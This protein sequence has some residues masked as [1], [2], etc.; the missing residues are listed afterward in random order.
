MVRA[1]P[2]PILLLILSERYPARERLIPSGLKRF[3][4]VWNCSDLMTAR[5][6]YLKWSLW[7]GVLAISAG[8][9][10]LEAALD[11]FLWHL[12]YGGSAGVVVGAGFALSRTH[13]PCH[14]SLW[15]LIGYAYMIVPDLLWALPLIWGGDVYSHQPWMDIFLGHVFLDHWAFTTAMLLPTLLVATLVWITARAAT[16]DEGES[17]PIG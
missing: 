9:Y 16:V 5:S 4:P 2:R 17:P 6:T 15:A 10:L 1:V 11:H 12:V 14:P 3:D 13:P 8:P 7:A